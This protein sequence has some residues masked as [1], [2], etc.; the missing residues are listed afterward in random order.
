MAA[1]ELS[2]LLVIFII[3]VNSPAAPVLDTLGPHVNP[4]LAVFNCYPFFQ[5][6][7]PTGTYIDLF[8]GKADMRQQEDEKFPTQVRAGEG[9]GGSRRLVRSAH[10]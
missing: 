1:F 2:G 4:T 3:F 9:E 5:G 8:R 7:L 6:F 10:R